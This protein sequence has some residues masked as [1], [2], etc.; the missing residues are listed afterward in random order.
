MTMM[1]KLINR[2]LPMKLKSRELTNKRDSISNN[3]QTKVLKL[4][5]QLS[6]NLSLKEEK[7]MLRR[8]EITE[9]LP[10]LPQKSSDKVTILTE[11]VA[12]EECR[13]LFI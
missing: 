8:L 1:R 6:L 10:H 5:L 13:Y 11:E 4:V 12:L 2:L 9:L 3:K 7:K